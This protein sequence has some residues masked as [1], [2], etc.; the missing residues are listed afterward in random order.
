MKNELYPWLEGVWSQWKHNLDIDQF[1]NVSLL[2]G[3][4]GLGT[5]ELVR[6]LSLAIMCTNQTTEPC[7]Y[8]HSCNLMASSTHPDYHLFRPEKEGKAISVDQI[9]QCN[10]LAQ[11][12][13]Q[14]SHARL[15]VIESAHSLNESAANALLKT[16]ESAHSGCFFV[17]LTDK[18][19]LLLPTIV[20]RCQQWS[21]PT[22]SSQQVTDWVQKETRKACPQYVAHICNYEPLKTRD[23]IESDQLAR[24]QDIESYFLKYLQ[25]EESW[26]STVAT[27]NKEPELTLTWIWYL[28]SDAQKWHFQLTGE[29]A[30]PGSEQLSALRSYDCLYKMNVALTNLMQQLKSSSGLNSELLIAN[31]L[32]EYEEDTCL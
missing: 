22:P 15:I 30:T 16:L 24:Y 14:L 23:F 9:R 3:A 1:S 11:E 13:S 7:G 12:S 32:I 17:L 19:N 10:K 18:L 6:K 8:C 25:G 28:I 29:Q 5:N 27:L 31:W 26:S 4:S 2:V 21:I 20:S